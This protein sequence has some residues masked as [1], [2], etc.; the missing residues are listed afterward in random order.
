MQSTKSGI[1]YKS[2]NLD[3][4]A[5]REAEDLWA[6]S[7][8]RM[9]P[10]STLKDSIAQYVSLGQTK[11][12]ESLPYNTFK[13]G[14]IRHEIQTMSIDQNAEPDTFSREPSP[15]EFAA[16]QNVAWL[17]PQDSKY[18]QKP[19]TY[20]EGMDDLMRA[21][22]SYRYKTSHAKKS[23]RSVPY[24]RTDRSST[25]LNTSKSAQGSRAENAGLTTGYV[26]GP[27][28]LGTLLKQISPENIERLKRL[29][30]K[31]LR[32]VTGGPKVSITDPDLVALTRA[33]FSS[34]N[35]STLLRQIPGAAS[36]P[37]IDYIGP[38]LSMTTAG[39]AAFSG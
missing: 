26:G 23:D 35:F 38:L 13:N 15:L 12:L 36:I 4:G 22:K 14:V 27:A 19:N 30:L 6:M 7:Q 28:G 37:G 5:H 8:A 34:Q 18:V 33:G 10:G 9:H 3:D 17:L 21:R 39:A 32:Q 16:L 2:R 29:G 20:A 1:S 24:Q 31:L 11:N 25:T